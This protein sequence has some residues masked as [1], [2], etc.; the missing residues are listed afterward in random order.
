MAITQCISEL[1]GYL[2]TQNGD[3]NQPSR[4]LLDTLNVSAGY[5]CG[6]FNSLEQLLKGIK[7]TQPVSYTHLTLPTTPYV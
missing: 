6:K 5:E 1:E 2:A 3:Q 7:G 4:K